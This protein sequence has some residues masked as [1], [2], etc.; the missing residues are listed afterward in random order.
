[1]SRLEMLRAKRQNYAAQLRQMQS[2]DSAHRARNKSPGRSKSKSKGE[3]PWYRRHSGKLAALG[4]AAA[5]AAFGPVALAGIAGNA[6]YNR[7][8]KQAK[9]APKDEGWGSRLSRFVG[10]T[11]GKKKRKKQRK[12]PA[13]KP[14]NKPA[15]KKP[16][17]RRR[18]APLKA[19]HK[20][21]S[22]MKK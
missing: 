8:A 1:M 20:A 16:P 5:T 12:K 4:T 14:A 13:K 10:L 15:K 21:P 17:A 2:D 18:K 22:K 19:P 11:G 6:A 7:Y 3:Q 9:T